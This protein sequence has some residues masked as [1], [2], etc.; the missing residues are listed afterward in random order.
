[1]ALVILAHPDFARSVANK[2]VLAHLQAVLPDIEVR[3]L[4]SLYPDYR[5]D[6]AAEQQALLRHQ[7]VVFQYPFY[8]YNMPAI[9]KQYFDSVF[10]Y[11]FAYGRDGDKLK[12]RNFVPSFTVGSPE[13]DY[14]AD[15]LAHFRVLEFCK[16]LEQTAY[17]TQMR[18]IDPFYFHGTSP[19]L[20]SREEVQA[21]AENCATGLVSL[22]QKL[23]G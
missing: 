22:L 1:M 3:D 5:I 8:W 14:R 17:Y 7:T 23:G 11:G 13:E 21:K 4:A 18:Y 9:L 20:Y 10:T 12:G 15:G 6:A 16:N 19:A 2:A